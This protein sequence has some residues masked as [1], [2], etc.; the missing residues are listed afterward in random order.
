MV[1]SIYS[2]HRY[3]LELKYTTMVDIHSRPTLPRVD[4]HHVVHHLNRVE[5]VQKVDI[6]IMMVMKLM[7]MIMKMKMILLRRV[8]LMIAM[9]LMLISM[10]VKVDMYV[11]LIPLVIVVQS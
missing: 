8:L 6:L 7:I 1:L 11:M 3:E 4:M 9:L 10:L 5:E 2:N